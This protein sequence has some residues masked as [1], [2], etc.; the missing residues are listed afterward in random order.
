MLI[1]EAGDQSVL[2]LLQVDA[3]HFG[4]RRGPLAVHVER[5]GKADEH[6]VAAGLVHVGMTQQQP[7]VGDHLV[8]AVEQ[9]Q[10]HQFVGL[11]IVDHL[12]PH[13][14]EGG[15]PSRKLVLQH[16]LQEIFADHGPGVLDAELLGDHRTVRLGG[17]GG[18]AVYHTVR[19]GDVLAD[20]TAQLSVAE[21]S[22]GQDHAPR[23]VTVATDIVTA[24]HGE[25]RTAC[26]TPAAQRLHNEAEQCFGVLLVAAGEISSHRGGISPELPGGG[27]V[28]VTALGDGQ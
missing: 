16:P 3:R 26:C 8:A 19:E 28:V 23:E 17:R 25:R 2:V 13:L 11:H 14:L 20:P 4:Q 1:V 24:E 15:A 7:E 21:F 6:L 9:T 18:N 22:E 12:H 10:L 27:V 5:T